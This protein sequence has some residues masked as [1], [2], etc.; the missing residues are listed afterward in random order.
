MQSY[1]TIVGV[2]RL[3]SEGIPF[4]ECEARYQIGSWT[5]QDI[6][7]KYRALG[8]TL[9]QLETMTPEDVEKLFYPAIQIRHKK[10]PLP[11]FEELF[12]KVN[13]A[14]EL[15]QKID[16]WKEYHKETPD[17][18]QRSQFMEYYNRYLEERFGPDDCVMGVNR[19]PGERVF[20]DYCGDHAF[21]HI[22]D[23]SKDPLDMTEQQEIHIFLTTC[24]YSSRIYSEASLDE[25]QGT[26]NMETSHA[27][28]F[29]GAV[30]KYLV[31]DNLKTGVKI[32]TKDEVI[33]NASYQDLESF[34]DT[35]VLP[36]PYRKPHGKPTAERYVKVIQKK[37]IKKLQTFYTFKNLDEVNRY[38]MDIVNRENE[39][40]MEGYTQ[41]HNEL[42]EQYDKPAMKPLKGSSFLQCDYASCPRIPKNY[43]VN[44][45]GHFYSVPHRY[46]GAVAIVKAT[47]G[48]IIICD[49][50]NREIAR[51]KRSYI[52]TQ[53]FITN[54]DHEPANHRFYEEVN[55]RTSED[56]LKWAEG[57][58]PNMRQMIFKIMK[59]AKHDEQM[60]PACNSI[61]HMC[62]GLP[63]GLCEEA[64]MDCVKGSR[65]KYSEFKETLSGLCR[66]MRQN[67]VSGS[68]PEIKDVRGKD[69]YK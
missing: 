6:M 56:Y 44:Y 52:P 29:Y 40:V 34:Y 9:A 13:E 23:L 22:M 12:K 39:T 41:S 64:A 28:E 5:A 53:R 42:F 18:F 51:H 69:Y 57:V 32:N 58:G 66:Q 62:D 38:L 21:I 59:S 35:I 15:T 17:G 60:Y 46:C 1:T 31:P 11:D 24:G 37:I 3:R 55:T 4:P 43:H 30:P 8:R 48:E 20:I 47:P 63:S 14:G 19:I 49:V 65:C 45:D 50:N 2:I 16:I 26:F 67:G 61:L 54:P 33:I 10:I 36:P 25:K 7:K 68:L 27:L